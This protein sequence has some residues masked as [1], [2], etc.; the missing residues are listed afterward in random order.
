MSH[1]GQWLCNDR[2]NDAAYA[3]Q[4]TRDNGYVITGYAFSWVTGGPDIVRIK[5]DS[6]GDTLWTKTYGDIHHDVGYVVRQLSDNGYII[7]GY[8]G[9]EYV[10]GLRVNFDVY[11]IRTDANGDVLWTKTYGGSELDIGVDIRTTADDGYVVVGQTNSFGAGTTDV[12]L[13][14]LKLWTEY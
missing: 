14:K 9:H 11:I 6:S 13:L 5:T 2:K 8:T 12:Y 10:P 7:A 1:F 4:Q 3:V